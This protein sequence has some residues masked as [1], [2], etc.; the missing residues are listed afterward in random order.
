MLNGIKHDE[1][2]KQQHKGC[3]KEPSEERL[4][5]T[6][7]TPACIGRSISQRLLRQ[8]LGRHAT[9]QAVENVAT[10]VGKT[11]RMMKAAWAAIAE[12]HNV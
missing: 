6:A 5:R 9:A 1:K 11:K 2:G 4:R 3:R 7:A 8:L 10:L 12:I